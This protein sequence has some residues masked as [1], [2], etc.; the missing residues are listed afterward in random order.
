M[1][2]LQSQWILNVH[3]AN[4]FNS[5]E[6]QFKRTSNFVTE[7]FSVPNATSRLGPSITRGLQKGDWQVGYR[8]HRAPGLTL[9]VAKPYF[10][11]SKPQFRNTDGLVFCPQLGGH[12][13]LRNC[14]APLL[15]SQ[16]S[17][18]GRHILSSLW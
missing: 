7:V 12:V 1:S 8:G 11:V 15:F 5:K 3:L 14:W 4:A 13:P 10:R 16:L 2:Y 17:L 6:M 18:Q 9:E